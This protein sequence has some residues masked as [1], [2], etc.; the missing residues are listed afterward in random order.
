MTGRIFVD[1]LIENANIDFSKP[2]VWDN[3]P[4]TVQEVKD[5]LSAGEIGTDIPYGDGCKYMLDKK[6]KSYHISRVAY[7]VQHPKEITDI[8]IDNK[9]EQMY[10][11]STAVVV[12]GWHRLMAAYILGLKTID[13]NYG[14]R[15]DV[16]EYLKGL[17]DE[18]DLED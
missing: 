10:I 5:Y 17:R 9:C 1:R 16:L 4:V 7:F 8:D 11:T 2:F 12:D 13:V 3:Q 15:D 14:G 18:E 6:D